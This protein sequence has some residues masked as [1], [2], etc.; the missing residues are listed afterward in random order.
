MLTDFDLSCSQGTTTAAL[1]TPEPP[2]PAAGAAAAAAAKKP[3]LGRGSAASAAAAADAARRSML[4]KAQPDGRANSFVGT[5]EYLAPEIIT[6]TGHTSQVDWWSFGILV[7][8]LVHGTTPFR[9]A[10]RD[11][12][13]DNIL[14]QPLRFPDNSPASADCRD[15]ISRLLHKVCAEALLRSTACWE[16]GRQGM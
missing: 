16:Q 12:T 7:Y 15:L 1:L 11:A 4:L 6:G 3:S 5:E 13:F 2:N 14:K 9:G 10:R 8:E